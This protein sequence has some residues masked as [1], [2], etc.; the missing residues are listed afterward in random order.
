V[1]YCQSWGS[2][3][4]A[5]LQMA[6]LTT[7]GAQGQALPPRRGL[8]A[9]RA[10]G[11]ARSRRRAEDA[12]SPGAGRTACLP[13]RSLALIFKK[14]STRTRV[15]FEVG[16]CQLGGTGV[17]ITAEHTHL[18]RGETLKDT[19]CV[20]SRYVDAIVI[21]TGPHSE[22]D[23]LA[24]HSSVPVL[25]RAHRQLAPLSGAGRR[26]DDPRALR[27]ARG[28]AP[29]L[30]SAT[31]T[32]SAASLMVAAAKLGMSFVGAFPAR[33]RARPSRP[34]P[35]PREAAAESGATIEIV[36]DPEQAAAAAD[37]L[38][39][40]VW[41]SMGEEDERDERLAAFQGYS[42][43]TSTCSSW[44]GPKP[45]SCTA[46]RRT[47]ARRSRKRSPT[48]RAR[49]SGIRPRTACTPRRR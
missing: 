20:L 42:G 8:E 10:E 12:S 29:R 47:T 35:T 27:S 13:G 36:S 9:R 41:V 14:A 6:H 34:W 4:S 46:C 17:S 2:L 19:A 38:Y 21:R 33:I 31:A 22:V 24:S 7:T 44:R 26:D 16:I 18:A 28:R 32:T 49:R 39:T 37:V 5:P 48:A 3:N 45:S 40:D 25:E 11:R 43:S 23:E 30:L 1:P 15:S